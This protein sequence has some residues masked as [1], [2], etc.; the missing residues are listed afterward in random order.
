[1]TTVQTVVLTT[2]EGESDEEPTPQD[3]DD[4]DDDDPDHSRGLCLCS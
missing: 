3:P 4:P 1:M 2:P